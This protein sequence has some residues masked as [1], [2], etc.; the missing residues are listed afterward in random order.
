MAENMGNDGVLAN[1]IVVL[2]TLLA[3]VT[4]TGWIFLLRTLGLL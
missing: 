2:T 4:I 1:G 3:A